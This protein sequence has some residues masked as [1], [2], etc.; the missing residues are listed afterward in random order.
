MYTLYVIA[1]EAGSSECVGV[2]LRV[3]VGYVY[4][5]FIP[6]KENHQHILV[7]RKY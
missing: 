6:A 1:R 4:D 7:I 3:C 2:L 5:H